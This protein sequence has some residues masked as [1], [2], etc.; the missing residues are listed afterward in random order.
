[1]ANDTAEVIVTEEEGVLGKHELVQKMAEKT[2]GKL[3]DMALAYDALT[4]ALV[5]CIRE[6]K[7]IRLTNVGTWKM[8]THQATQRRNPKTGEPIMLPERQVYRFMASRAFNTAAYA[9][10]KKYSN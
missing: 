10:N 7:T 6:H 3:K 5:D 8:K 9:N 1:M 2:G 4:E